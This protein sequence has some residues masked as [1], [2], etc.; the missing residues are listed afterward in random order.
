M[1]KVTVQRREVKGKGK[2]KGKGNGKERE[3]KETK[4][5]RAQKG[6]CHG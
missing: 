3:R 4:Q 1:L 5:T 2:G 6:A